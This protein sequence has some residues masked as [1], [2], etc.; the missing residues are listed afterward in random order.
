MT[1]WKEPEFNLMFMFSKPGAYHLSRGEENQDIICHDSNDRFTV[2][3]LADGVSTCQ[4]ARAGAE[5][6]GRAITR[7]FL[8]NGAF[9]MQMQEDALVKHALKCVRYQLQAQAQAD[10]VPVEE[11]ASTL[12]S[13]LIDR[14]SKMLR[15]FHLGDGLIL[16]LEHGSCRL[17]AAPSDSTGG[18]YVT[19]TEGVAGK[20][21]TRQMPW[22]ALQEIMLLSDGAWRLMYDK[23]RML[24]EV[25]RLLHSADY[26]G[27]QEYLSQSDSSDD[28]SFICLRLDRKKGR[29]SA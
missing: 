13:V 18:C 16:G 4:K 12:S 11:Y 15:C 2:I 27:L 21:V 10:G 28:C 24:P 9:F 14:G 17:L 25:E 20:V 3:T 19:T 5:I 1:K 22:E 26:A 8:D 29:K 6:A 7:L 23:T